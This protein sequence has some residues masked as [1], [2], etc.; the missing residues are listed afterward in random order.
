M[1]GAE[2]ALQVALEHGIEVCFANP[3]TTELP[4]VAALDRCPA[5]R[6]V[7]GL[8]E[9]VCTGGADGYARMAGKP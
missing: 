9:G 6:P 7:L 4:L 2:A 3:G 5:I 8:F 1:T